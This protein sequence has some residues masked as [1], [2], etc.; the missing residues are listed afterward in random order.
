[1]NSLKKQLSDFFDHQ[2]ES[3]IALQELSLER[4]KAL[5]L[6][7]DRDMFHFGAMCSITTVLF[8]TF[9]AVKTKNKAFAAPCPFLV[10]GAGYY[11]EKLFNHGI[12]LKSTF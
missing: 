2:F 11:Y 5:K 10:F 3:E 7:R 12:K 6:S 4:E 8:L 1:M 9:L